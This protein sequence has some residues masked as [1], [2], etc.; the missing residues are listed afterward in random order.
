M[1]DFDGKQNDGIISIS[2]N[3]LKS[4]DN[5]VIRLEIDNNSKHYIISLQPGVYR[6][7][8]LFKLDPSAS[9]NTSLNNNS[10]GIEELGGTV[11]NSILVKS[12]TYK[13]HIESTIDIVKQIGGKG[14]SYKFFM[15]PSRGSSTVILQGSSIFITQL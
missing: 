2:P 4:A 13:G 5:E 1:G 12:D 8:V 6:I 3:I 10:V 11:I 15:S 7:T 9:T 14:A